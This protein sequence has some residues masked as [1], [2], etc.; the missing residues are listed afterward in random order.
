MIVLRVTKGNT[1]SNDTSHDD[2]NNTSHDEVRSEDTHGRN[3]DARLGGTVTKRLFRY[4]IF[5]NNRARTSLQYLYK[6]RERESDIK[7]IA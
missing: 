3:A 4:E 2:W 1:D 5:S 6:E 7:S